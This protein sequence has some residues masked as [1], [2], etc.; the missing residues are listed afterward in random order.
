MNI[1]S[2]EQ[3]TRDLLYRI[4]FPNDQ[5]YS[6]S[7]LGE[8]ADLFYKQTERKIINKINILHH[9]RN[10]YRIDDTDLRK[11]RLYAADELERLYLIEEKI[12]T[13]IDT[14]ESFKDTILIKHTFD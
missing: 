11:V 2:V 7:E 12:K 3:K 5:D 1:K 14:M 4:E 13:Y 6:A 10:P 8:L 9:L